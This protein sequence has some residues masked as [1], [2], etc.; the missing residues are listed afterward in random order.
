MRRA[1]FSAFGQVFH[2]FLLSLVWNSLSRCAGACHELTDYMSFFFT[3][4][5]VAK[6]R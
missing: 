3:H 4:D 5:R 6:L 1:Q 2:H